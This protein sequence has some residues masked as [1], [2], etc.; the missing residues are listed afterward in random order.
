MKGPKVDVNANAAAAKSKG[1]QVG[2]AA[3][4]IGQ[5][6]A[7]KTSGHFESTHVSIGSGRK[8]SVRKAGS[9]K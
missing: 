7:I 6:P 4:G 5:N 8:T 3:A 1:R 2:Q 9:S